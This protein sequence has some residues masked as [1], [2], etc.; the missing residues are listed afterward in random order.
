MEKTDFRSVS[1]QERGIILR[2]PIRMIKRGDKKKE[3]GLFY[4]VHVFGCRKP[5]TKYKNK[6]S[7]EKLF[8]VF[9]NDFS[10]WQA[11][12]FLGIHKEG[13]LLQLRDK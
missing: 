8:E 7:P 13:C 9:L 10:K 5:G 6:A 4:R 12:Y 11:R 1:Y 3:I 2:D